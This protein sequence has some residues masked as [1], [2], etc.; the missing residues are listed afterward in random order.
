MD[1]FI[2]N[3]VPLDLMVIKVLPV[4][5][6]ELRPS[7]VLDGNKTASSDLNELYKGVI[8]ANNVLV[9]NIEGQRDGVTDF[10]KYVMALEH[11]QR[12][13]DGLIDNSRRVDEPVDYNNVVLRSLIEMLKGKR[14]M[15]RH[16]IL[17]KGVDYSGRG[18]IVLGPDLSIN[19]CVIPRSMAAE[20]FKPFIHSKPMLDHKVRWNKDTTYLL[21]YDYQ[22]AYKILEEIVKYCSV[23]L[24]RAP[25]LHKLSMRSFWVK[26]T[27]KKVIR[28]HPLVCTGFNAD[29]DGDQMA[30]HVPLSQK[31]RVEAAMLLMAENNVFHSAHGDPCVLP[32][33]DM[34]LGMYY[35]SLTSSKWTNICFT[36]YSEVTIALTHKKLV[37]ILK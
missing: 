32:S 3:K 20:L 30:V 34:I 21:A 37:Y 1:G 13:V 10:D 16:N 33:Q 19:E 23:V 8:N 26:L 17:G 7:V 24:N 36:S 25:T 11:L 29:F 4:L 9:V 12:N 15:F 31:V 18:V 22:M 14:G 2:N 28:L 5:P 27:N 35:M 6:I